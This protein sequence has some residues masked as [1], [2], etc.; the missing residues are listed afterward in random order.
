MLEFSILAIPPF[1]NTIHFGL[2][3]HSPFHAPRSQSAGT[4]FQDAEPW[5]SASP[6]LAVGTE[7]DWLKNIMT[8]MIMIIIKYKQQ[9][10]LITHE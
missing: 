3:E 1:P 5:F 10:V 8:M 9:N 2:R 4:A 6:D 7:R